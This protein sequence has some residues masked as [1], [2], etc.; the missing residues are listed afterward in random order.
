MRWT[1]REH[2]MKFNAIGSWQTDGETVVR[3]VYALKVSLP[4]SLIVLPVQCGEVLEEPR[5]QLSAGGGVAGA[6]VADVRDA[7]PLA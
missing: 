4:D 6:D 5:V 1:H 3:Y 2:D 7:V